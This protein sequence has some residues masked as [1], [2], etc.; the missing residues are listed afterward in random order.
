MNED[1]TNL[2]TENTLRITGIENAIDSL[3]KAR[4]FAFSEDPFKWKWIALTLHDSLYT[5]ALAC[6][7]FEPS[8]V[9]ETNNGDKGIVVSRN[10]R[11]DGWRKSTV[12]FING[13][14]ENEGSRPYRIRWKKTE[15][16]NSKT[17]KKKRERVIG[18]WSAI[19]RVQ[20]DFY[21]MKYF[22]ET[23][24]LTLS[25]DELHELWYLQDSIRNNLIH[26][27]PGFHEFDVERIR[28][29]CLVAVGAISFLLD[30]S[31][32]AV[33]FQMTDE[34]REKSGQYLATLTDILQKM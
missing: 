27:R 16:I 23:E 14:G 15:K 25:D 17:K 19:A 11:P 6:I 10:G 22:C 18:F 34:L 2:G 9:V 30:Q 12:E 32:S 28:S 4:M 1:I 24:A 8:F 26:C 5:V 7:A 31:L 29:S 20:D 21:W 3:E 13:E 33:H